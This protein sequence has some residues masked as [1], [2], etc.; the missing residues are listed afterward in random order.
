MEE[1]VNVKKYIL[2]FGLIY[3]IA[4]LIFIYIE[5]YFKFNRHWFFSI[6]TILGAMIA[7]SFF[8][9]DNH[10]IPNKFEKS[11]L[12]WQSIVVVIFID[13]LI[14]IVQV[15]YF[16]IS[17]APAFKNLSTASTALASF[18]IIIVAL[19]VI[20]I[21]AYIALFL[22]YGYYAKSQHKNIEKILNKT[23]TKK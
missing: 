9:L 22:I 23:K 20:G 5:T 8:I 2:I 10:R 4:S 12:I 6:E 16:N 13:M 11:K 17:F 7:V 18:I 19:L 14:G 15:F 3:F 21:P 1:N